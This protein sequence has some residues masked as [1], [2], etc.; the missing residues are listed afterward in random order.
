[1][2]MTL[3]VDILTLNTDHRGRVVSVVVSGAGP[4][5]SP[6]LR[7]TFRTKVSSDWRRHGHAIAV[8]ISDWSRSWWRAQSLDQ[9]RTL[10]PSSRGWRRRRRGRRG[11]RWEIF[12]LRELLFPFDPCPGSRQPQFPG[13]VLD[14]H[15]A[16]GALHGN[17][18]GRGTRGKL[19]QAPFQPM[20]G[21]KFENVNNN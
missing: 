17:Q 11:A 3:Q 5:A 10:P 9:R 2:I 8:L 16:R 18:R 21:R 7:D 20:S 1:M 15:R 19:D 4:T 13:Q 12:L 6:G 14:V